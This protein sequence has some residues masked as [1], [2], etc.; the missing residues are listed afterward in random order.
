MF[1]KIEIKRKKIV[2]SYN[3]EMQRKYFNNDMKVIIGLALKTA[4]I[5]FACLNDNMM[6]AVNVIL[7][8][9]V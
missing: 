8:I 3:I 6:C 5:I 7:S 9:D 4:V 1:R 2:C